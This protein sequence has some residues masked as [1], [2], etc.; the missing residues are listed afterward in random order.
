[1]DDNSIYISEYGDG[2]PS[3]ISEIDL[4]Q[5]AKVGD[6]YEKIGNKYV[7]NPN[8]TKELNKIRKS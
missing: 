1:M 3:F 4:P 2:G 6:V 8:I 5:N 7:Y